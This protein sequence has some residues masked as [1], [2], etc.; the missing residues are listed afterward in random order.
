MNYRLI[1]WR[2]FE[3][4]IKETNKERK[5][6]GGGLSVAGAPRL[7]LPLLH[8]LVSWVLW[9]RY[10]RVSGRVIELS[11]PSAPVTSHRT[12]WI[13]ARQAAAPEVPADERGVA[14]STAA[15]AGP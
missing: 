14:L 6:S 1:C 13:L 9:T 10:Y 7:R 4:C 15:A 3:K 5:K 11:R 2:S 12:A 8:C